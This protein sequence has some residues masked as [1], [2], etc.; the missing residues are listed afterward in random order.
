MPRPAIDEILRRVRV[1][2]EVSA[3]THS[4]EHDA[5]PI[6]LALSNSKRQ[7]TISVRISDR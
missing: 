2:E 3:T 5:D 1:E 4:W 6:P 7:M